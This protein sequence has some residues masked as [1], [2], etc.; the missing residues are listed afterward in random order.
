MVYAKSNSAVPASGA[1]LEMYTELAPWFHLLTPPAEYAGEAAF[2]AE[3]LV[4]ACARPPRSMLELGSGAGCNALHLKERFQMTLVDLSEAM[5]DVSHG[6]N[7]ECEH[8]PGDMRTVRLD[9][10]T[11][12]CVMIHDA[13]VYMTTEADLRR[14]ME[15]AFIHCAPGGAVLLAP[16]HTKE[17]FKP[18]TQHGG[19]D[20]G[21]RGMRY[22]EW[23]WAPEP[24]G[25]TYVAD[26]AYLL[27]EEDG[28]V[29]QAG[30]RHVMGLFSRDRWLGLLEEVG[31]AASVVSHEVDGEEL[32]LFVGQRPDQ[33]VT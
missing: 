19:I 9:R 24:G 10:R 8:L 6:L 16:D 25:G 23:T 31:F 14:A 3:T 22:L 30:E 5:L 12:D 13:V 18:S 33:E 11:F 15:T 26:F 32:L 20:Q 2:Y 29:Q 4:E 7:P 27:R 28:T 21:G 17:T 1:D